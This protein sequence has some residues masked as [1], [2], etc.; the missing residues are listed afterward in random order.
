MT[1]K[2]VKHKRSLCGRIRRVSLQMIAA[3]GILAGT[4]GLQSCEKDILEGQ[5][6][7]LGN[8]IYERLQE[9]IT[10][11]D[12]STKYFN[13][14]MRLIDDLGYTPIL[15]QTGSRT[16]FVTPD[17]DYDAWFKNNSWGVTSY[18]ELSLAQKKQLFNSTMIKNA[19]LLELMSNVPAASENVEPEDGMSMRRESAN[20]IWDNVPVM[21]SSQFQSN[22]LQAEEPVNIAWKDVRDQGKDIHILKDAT[23]APMIHF[24]PKF[25]EKNN[26]TDEDLRIISN[27]ESNSIKDAW[28]N[29]RK[30]ISSEQICKNGYIYVISGVMGNNPNMAQIIHDTE[31]T[32]YWAQILDRWSVPEYLGDG[33]IENLNKTEAERRAEKAEKVELQETFWRLYPQYQGEPLYQLRYMNESGNNP[34]KLPVPLNKTEKEFKTF[35]KFDPSWNQYKVD[36]NQVLLQNDAAAMLVPTDRALEDWFRNGGGKVIYDR[37]NPSGNSDFSVTLKSIPYG[38][39]KSLVNVN[40]LESFVATIPSKF[41][42]IT[43]ETQRKMGVTK[44]NI[45]RCY[46]GCNG[47]VYVTN[48]VFAPAEYSSVLFPTN[49]EQE[50]KFSVMYGALTGRYTS[51]QNTS[52]DF[53]PY[54]NAMDSRFSLIVPFNKYPNSYVS[55]LRTYGPVFR[56]LD[57]CGFGFGQ[58]YLFEFYVY[59]S[60]ITARAYP[61]KVEN[62]IVTITNTTGSTVTDEV[63]QNRLFDYINNSII[64]DDI[65]PS[66]S[67]YLTKA[68]S[69]MYAQN[70]GNETTFKGGF[71]LNNGLEVKVEK[72]NIYDM[73]ASGNGKTYGVSSDPSQIANKMQKDVPMQIDLPMTS[74][75][76]VYDVLTEM[77]AANDGYTLFYDLIFND[78]SKDEKNNDTPLYAEQDGASLCL[79]GNK[80]ITLFDNYNYTVY[81]PSDAAIQDMI[82][83]YYLPT[84][85]DYKAATTATERN[86]IAERIHNF[87]RYHVQDNSVYRYGKSYSNEFFET[88]KLNSATN[89][90][91]TLKVTQNGGSM[92]V[93]DNS[94]KHHNILSGQGESNIACREYWI[95]MPKSTTSSIVK[96]TQTTSR[97]ATIESSSNIV[98]HK[99]DGALIFDAKQQLNNW[100]Y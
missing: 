27:G 71:Q 17:E 78:C 44:D 79:N 26:F 88:A 97:N 15:S 68:G 56:M 32:K 93:I 83:N 46:M 53:S 59:N 84:W 35:L 10:V 65:D 43:D 70:N 74:V 6:E 69:V 12:G 1:T 61:C 3:C 37:F 29:G 72:E 4:A 81:V 18:E 41:D 40:M 98:V 20:D 25:M 57:P 66:K 60:K 99:I 87:V 54:L 11:N 92:S 28:I 34:L 82:N 36:N 52:L 77:K 5:P 89:R 95:K 24:L 86:K 7:K 96:P 63:V 9:G 8:S 19:N 21:T 49:Q 75:K 94:G 55:P 100:H 14:T 85:D 51:S 58:Q 67:F 73:G 42:A 47:V 76:S 90:F 13:Y 48:R 31:N 33:G 2:I 80:N 45:E 30:V 91:Y 39:L 16:L 22:T 62:G 64:I 23:S 38:I 50:G